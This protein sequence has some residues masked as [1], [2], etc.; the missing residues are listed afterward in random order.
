MTTHISPCRAVRHSNVLHYHAHHVLVFEDSGNPFDDIA[1]QVEIDGNI[2]I[3]MCFV[4]PS[5]HREFHHIAVK[6][7]SSAGAPRR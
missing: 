7:Q 5:S 1:P 3:L 2:R 4:D 6:Q